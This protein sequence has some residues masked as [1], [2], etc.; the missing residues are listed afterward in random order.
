MTLEEWELRW[1][2]IV[3]PQALAELHAALVDVAK[4]PE[5]DDARSEA[6]AASEGRL[7]ASRLGV[8]LWRNNVG[9]LE[10]ENGRPIRYGLANESKKMNAVLKSGDYIG[11]APYTVTS[12]DIGRRLGVFTSVEFKKPQWTYSGT[13]REQAQVNWQTAVNTLGG[14]AFFAT[15][16]QSVIDNLANRR[17]LSLDPL[18]SAQR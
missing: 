14:V 7:T 12:A 16:G 5:S 1:R 2:G 18:P 15:G 17:L 6:F 13:P 11:V 4:P 3:P 9:V 8:V 10:D